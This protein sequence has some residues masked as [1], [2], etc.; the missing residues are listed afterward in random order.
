MKLTKK[1]V[2]AFVLL[3]IMLMLLVYGI[4]MIKHRMEYAVTDAVFVDTEDINNVG[5]QKVNGK[6]IVM[7]KKEGEQVKKGELLAKIDPEPYKLIVQ[8]LEQKLA[9]KRSKRE[10]LYIK[11]KKTIEILNLKEKIALDRVKQT[12]DEIEALKDS[13]SS[14]DAQI[15]QLKRDTLR[16]KRLYEKGAVAKRTYETIET[17]LISKKRQRE[18][19]VKKLFSLKTQLSIAKKDI[20]LVRANKKDIEELRREIKAISKEI[21]SLEARL[22]NAKL[23]LKYCELTSPINGRVAKKYRS[24]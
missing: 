10:K 7:T 1:N 12:K 15:Q 5:F 14:L 9:A 18:S 6:I 24:V 13:I 19:L 23:N 16:Y 3:L 4:L 8:E 20:L 2:T 22:K 21:S 11:L 17:E